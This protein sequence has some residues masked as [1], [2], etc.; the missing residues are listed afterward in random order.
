MSLGCDIGMA[1]DAYTVQLLLSGDDPFLSHQSVLC[2]QHC[3]FN[4]AKNHQDRQPGLHIK[5][6]DASNLVVLV[7]PAHCNSWPVYA[8][9]FDVAVDCYW[10]M[11]SAPTLRVLC[12]GAT[13][14]VPNS[15]SA[16]LIELLSGQT[17]RASKRPSILHM[18]SMTIFPGHLAP[19]VRFP[20]LHA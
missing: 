13:P 6:P 1:H 4:C 2:G 20:M 11:G 16:L 14:T 18:K 17:S 7:L 8:H 3:T 15:T 19:G 5:A 10:R 12:Q 9:M